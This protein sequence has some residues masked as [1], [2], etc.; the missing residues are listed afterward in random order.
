MKTIRAMLKVVML[1]LTVSSL[2]TYAQSNND[3]TKKSGFDITNLDR[4][5][6][7]A[8]DF[9]EFAVG[10]WVKK[11]PIPDD[12]TRW[13]S[14]DILQE[15]NNMILKK[16]LDEVSA[17]KDWEIGSVRQKIADFYSVAMDSDRIEKEGYKLIAPE[18]RKI[19]AMSNKE[20]FYKLLAEYHLAGMNTLFDFSCDVDAKRSTIMVSQINQRGVAL[21][22]VEYYTKDDSRSKEIRTK[23]IEHIANMFKLIGANEETAHK[24]AGII[25]DLE[26][27]LA[28]ASNTRVENRDPVKTYNKMLVDGLKNS[29]SGFDWD[30]YFTELGV[31][32]KVNV[33][34]VAQ[35]KF[36]AEV[37]DM[38]KNVPL[39][40]WK[41][42]LKWNLLNASASYLSS[43]F[44]NELFN[45]RG[46]FLSGAKVIQPRW[47]RVLATINRT[48]GELLGQIYVAE[49]FPPEAKAKAQSIVNSLL[50]SMGESIR[51]LDWMSASTK[52]KAL[53]KLSSFGVKIGYPDKWT[54]YSKLEIGQ[55][56]YI[57]NLRKANTWAKQ[58]ELSKIG[59]PVDKTEWGMSP[60][61][62]NA[63]Y[64]AERNEIV[65]PA[66]I[67]QWPF[68]SPESDDAVNYGAMGV[69]IGHEIT[70]G[71]DDQGRKFDAQGNIN[72]WWNSEDA[73]KFNAR[74]KKLVDEYN[75]FMPVDS[76]RVNGSLTLGENI[77][78]L[79]GLT[80]SFNAFKNTDQYKKGELIDGFTPSQRFY[81]GY[82]QVWANSIRDEALKLRLKTDPHSPGKQ[83]V[84]GPLMNLSD[85]FQAFDVK[86]GD[87]M[88]NPD[89]KIVKIW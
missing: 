22:D 43:P 12:Q 46:K 42:Y 56:D 79:G 4:N 33:V 64:S 55:D 14:F 63:Y 30:T 65:F 60:Q 54:D 77:A 6:S 9:Y 68:F 15:E 32:N 57:S 58:D 50:K 11:H 71:F 75:S 36:I 73:V 39:D 17:K 3:K 26:T 88:R 69:V 83:R 1:L 24:N 66:A 44:V 2:L 47:K 41:I 87:P 48:M 76:M 80:I 85:F 35:P 72:D 84:L 86:P 59:K 51:N 53:E 19:D 40:Q 81:L 25:L 7:P 52:E 21:P 23:Y 5:T 37:G 20:D 78:D 13:G 18:L 31:A 61:T 45:F 62:V 8:K 49:T 29:T 16:I 70:H 28:K 89:D 82:A 38:V 67:L 27:R 34:V 10:G 74:T